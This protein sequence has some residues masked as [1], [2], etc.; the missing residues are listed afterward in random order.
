[1]G[2]D[3]VKL[4]LFLILIFFV[5]ALTPLALFRVSASYVPFL[6]V[7][8]SLFL[9][10]VVSLFISR[11]LERLTSAARQIAG[12][13]LVVPK[14]LGWQ[15]I[16]P[17]EL[18]ELHQSFHDMVLQLRQSTSQANALAYVDSV[19]GLAN[20]E[21]FRRR[22][23]AFVESAGHDEGATLLFLDLDGFKSVND[24]KGHDAGDLVLK[25][26]AARLC[27]M[28]DVP[29]LA[30][31]DP[32][33]KYLLKRRNQPVIARLG[34]DEFAVFLPRIDAETANELADK[35]LSA[36]AVPFSI[37]ASRVAL[38]SSI[39]VARFPD[40]GSEYSSL[41]K[42]ADIAM[43]DAK[44]SGKN[45]VRPYFSGIQGRHS[46]RH[47]LADD[48]FSNEFV[49]QMD[50]L[51][52]PIYRAGDMSFAG[53]EGLIRWHHPS[54]GLLKPKDFLS[55]AATLGLQRQID[56]FAFERATEVLSYLAAGG[57]SP[58]RLSLNLSMERL[59]DRPFVDAIIG[60]QP[61]PFD[62]S[63][64]LVES[65][66]L[67]ALDSRIF[68]SIDRLKEA[69]VRVELDD[70]GSTHASLTSLLDLGPDRIK[71][72]TGLVARMSEGGQIRTIIGSL[73][74]MAHNLGVEVVGKGAENMEQVA[75]LANLGCDYIQGYALNMPMTR[76][77]LAISL[78]NSSAVS[79]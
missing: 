2:A 55:V 67:D 34:G 32:H 47:Y 25:N 9:A 39:G 50:V 12:G 16:L 41:L 75:E 65:S 1:M 13:D 52:Q 62:F 20:R 69:G 60:T 70:F 43:Y 28:I 15:R 36:L 30:D 37:D 66:F 6:G 22:V 11:P 17:L 3:T 56:K 48:L 51:Y 14:E 72:D 4:R 78:S 77:E 53:V 54:E 45:Q 8:G 61:L 35:V 58:V 19:T 7:S 49:D 46:S 24:T 68:W 33:Q 23:D 5:L 42:A 64:E 27:D 26:V 40:H 10:L 31:Q 44:R 57:T 18:R 29:S 63:I 76:S 73:V 74:D 71:L 79:A 59:I 21:Y 38:S